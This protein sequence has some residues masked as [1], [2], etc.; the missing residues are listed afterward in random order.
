MRERSDL[1]ALA[2]SIVGSSH[3][4]EELVQ[5]SWLRWV[6]RDYPSERSVPIF[7]RIVANL[8]KDW[9]RRQKI[10]AAGLQ[11]IVCDVEEPVDGERIVMA[12]QELTQVAK[13]LSELPDRTL[14]VFRMHRLEGLTYAEIGKHLGI[15]TT[16]V[17]Q[18]LQDA[19]VHVALRRNV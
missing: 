14:T 3:I 7:R 9:R 6:G 8:S 19:L 4:A 11:A 12:R 16:R 17:H 1:I 2:R 13:I 5:E 18:L 10:E 15:G